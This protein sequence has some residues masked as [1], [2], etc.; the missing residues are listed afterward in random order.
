M[1]TLTMNVLNL[2]ARLLKKTLDPKAFFG[3]SIFIAVGHFLRGLFFVTV[4]V[5]S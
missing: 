1:R 4:E 2:D 5:L 3:A